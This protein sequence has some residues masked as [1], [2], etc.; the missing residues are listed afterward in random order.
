MLLLAQKVLAVVT[1]VA[2][3][4]CGVICA[5]GGHGLEA[6]GAAKPAVAQAGAA[7]SAPKS[8]SHSH[9]HCGGHDQPAG[10]AHGPSDSSP[11]HPD[12]QHNSGCQHCESKPVVAEKSQTLRQDFQPFIFAPD[13]AVVAVGPVLTADHDA[14]PTDHLSP[15]VAGRSLLR[16]HCA[17]NL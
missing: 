2:V 13:L 17:L 3:F 8:G 10:P 4:A 15:R 1:A 5:C 7:V 14:A 11:A 12:P 6:K 16:Q 9:S